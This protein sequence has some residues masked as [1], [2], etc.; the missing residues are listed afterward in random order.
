MRNRTRDWWT[1]VLLVAGAAA[2]LRLLHVFELRDE[3]ILKTLIGDGQEYD[4][5]AVRIAAG[6]W[7][8]TD[9]FYQTPLYP[10]FVGL[11]YKVLGHAPFLLRLVQA[12]LGATSCVWL[13]IATRAFFGPRAALVGAAALAIYPP[14]VFFDGLVQKASLDL[15][16][17]T[18]LLAVAGSA[19][20]R[21]SPRLFVLMGLVI[22][23]LMLNRETTRVL[24][25]VVVAW[26][27]T[28]FL[29]WPLKQRLAWTAMLFVG[30]ALVTLPVA[31]RNLY[32]GGEFLIS[33]SQ[34]GPNLYIGNRHGANG[35]YE[36]LVPG[37]GHVRHER[38]DAVRLASAASGRTLTPRE[39]SAF[40]IRRTA[41]EIR[42]HPM[43]WLALMV[44]KLGLTLNAHEAT[45]TESLETYAAHSTV[46]YVLRWL[47]FGVLLSLAASG[48]VLTWSRRRRLR[49]LYWSAAALIAGIAVFYVFA[50]YRLV[51]V[52]V[53][54]MFAAAAISKT[55]ADMRAG[56]WKTA[57]RAS[58]AAVL[59]A[60][61]TFLPSPRSID[62]TYFNV[63]AELLRQRRF[64]E[65]IPLLEAAVSKTPQFAAAHYNLAIAL[66]EESQGGRSIVALQEALRWH[67]DFPE[68]HHLLSTNLSEHGRMMEALAAAEAAV[69]L[70]PQA[71]EYR[72]NL[73]VLLWRAGRPTDALPHLVAGCDLNP[74]D[75][76]ALNN[77][78]AALEQTGQSAQ[79]V[80]RLDAAIRLRPNYPE[81]RSNLAMSLVSLGRHREAAAHLQAALA[82]QPQNFAMR[83]NLARVWKDVG[84][85]DSAITEF[86][87]ALESPG[88][89]R[90]TA[91][92]TL[93]ELYLM[94]VEAG[95]NEQAQRALRAGRLLAKQE[96]LAFPLPRVRRPR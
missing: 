41:E 24:L 34:A 78:G 86:L 82:T 30:T 90:I 36:P 93:E 59:G 62:D 26:V 91:I 73:G 16:L 95:A 35:L 80:E 53:V 18:G 33:T 4:A 45:D 66:K 23:A 17:M 43:D 48:T 40:W 42:A 57:V 64:A 92:H 51:V 6:D 77:L 71:G 61:L 7:L 55:V 96:G 28:D 72:T 84:E 25:P 10:Y 50:R 39:V 76:V 68:A 81:A 49:V 2:A 47:N 65:A 3:P 87:Q 56:R 21:P 11:I 20:L 8:G 70:R 58:I 19:R 31:S 89:D 46:L 12:G 67:P 9:V 69:R 27:L 44:R 5:W 13:A 75:P 22:G 1:Q 74:M 54:I 15:W 37:R 29:R 63:G 60:G 38:A 88:V 83:M 52:P 79:A 32:V 85:T 14:A 94:C